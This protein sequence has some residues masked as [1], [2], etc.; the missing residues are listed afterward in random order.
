MLGAIQV[1]SGNCHLH[2][3][4]ASTGISKVYK[5][6]RPLYLSHML[7]GTNECLQEDAQQILKK[8]CLISWDLK[9]NDPP[10]YYSNDLCNFIISNLC[11]IYLTYDT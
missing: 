3:S 6:Y 1:K 8:T 10:S 11:S 9:R 5:A 2:S 7:I 4:A